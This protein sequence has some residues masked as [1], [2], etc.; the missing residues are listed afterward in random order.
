VRYALAPL[1]VLLALAKL[2][3][4]DTPSAIADWVALRAD[5]FRRSLG[6][7]WKRMPQA[8]TYRRLLDRGLDVA[9]LEEQAS[10][11]LGGPSS[12][13]ARTAL[14]SPARPCAARSK[15]GRRGA[16]TCSA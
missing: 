14:T 11:F 9:Q 6:L 7:R 13:P 16:C 10:H 1:L 2:A 8:G 15:P 12:A 4:Q 3:G 5:Y